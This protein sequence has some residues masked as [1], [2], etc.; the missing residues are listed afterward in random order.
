LEAVVPEKVPITE[1]PVALVALVVY[2][3]ATI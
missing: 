1:V 3:S 2:C